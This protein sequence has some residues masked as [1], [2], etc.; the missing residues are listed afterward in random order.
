MPENAG[1]KAES[2]PAQ[3]PRGLL[4]LAA[5]API[6][7]YRVRLGW[8]LGKRFLM[9][10]HVGRKTGL[11]RSVVLEVLRHD[12]PSGAYFVAAAY[13]TRSDWYRNILQTPEV[14]VH[15]GAHRFTGRAEV[16]TLEEGMDEIQAYAQRYPAAIRMISRVLG[17][18]FSFTQA[19]FR[20][21]VEKVPIVALRPGIQD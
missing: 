16:L 19:G 20:E 7:L 21:F 3:P 2:K 9:L 10:E 8:L 12:K 6:F 11:W 4:R 13:S 1:T 15:A 5:R 18:P 17:Y 14:R